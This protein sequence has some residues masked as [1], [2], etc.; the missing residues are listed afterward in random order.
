MLAKS[1]VNDIKVLLYNALIDSWINHDIFVS[2]NNLLRE[3]YKIKKTWN[4]LKLLSNILYENMLLLKIK[5]LTELCRK[6]TFIKDQES[7]SISND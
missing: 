7:N 4:I 3:Y 2:V 6:L 5:A 1:K